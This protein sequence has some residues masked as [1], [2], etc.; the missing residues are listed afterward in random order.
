[1][2]SSWWDHVQPQAGLSLWLLSYG[3][4]QHPPGAA[5]PAAQLLQG[6]PQCSFSRNR[7]QGFLGLLQHSPPSQL[8]GEGPEAA[9]LWDFLRIFLNTENKSVHCSWCVF[10]LAW[11]AQEFTWAI[12][13]SAKHQPTS[14]NTVLHSYARNE[15][16]SH[17]KLMASPKPTITLKP[18][19]H[20]RQINVHGQCQPKKGNKFKSLLSLRS[21][22]TIANFQASRQAKHHFQWNI[23]RS[24]QKIVQ[25]LN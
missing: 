4:Q 5:P 9:F 12:K 10:W 22:L 17:K 19:C 24:R 25:W 21:K 18:F 20:F 11:R 23:E 15:M 8:P 7:V 16:G 3:I 14:R 13:A 6:Q 1:M 2:T